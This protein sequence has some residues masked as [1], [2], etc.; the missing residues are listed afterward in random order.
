M[1][2]T[3]SLLPLAVIH[4]NKT[5][6]NHILRINGNDFTLIPFAEECESTHFIS[7]FII[8][9]NSNI[10]PLLN[11]LPLIGERYENTLPLISFLN[12]H[13]LFIQKNEEPTLICASPLGYRVL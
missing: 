10:I 12:L 6:R 1:E 5:Y 3:L 9:A 13:N 11:S 2:T 4:N 8:I 7:S